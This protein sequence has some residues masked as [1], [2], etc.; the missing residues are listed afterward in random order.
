MFVDVETLSLYFG[1][2]RAGAPRTIAPND[3]AARQRRRRS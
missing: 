3:R 1:A 2:M